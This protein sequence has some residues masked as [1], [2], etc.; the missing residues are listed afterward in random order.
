MSYKI[1]LSSSQGYTEIL[2][3]WENSVRNSPRFLSEENV[4][5]KESKIFEKSKVSNRSKFANVKY[6]KDFAGEN[7]FFIYDTATRWSGYPAI[8]SPMA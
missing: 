1:A 2:N 8:T 4:F 7:E 6:E 3:V 5:F